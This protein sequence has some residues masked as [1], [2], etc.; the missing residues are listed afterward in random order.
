MNKEILLAA[1]SQHY[2]FA[3]L[4]TQQKQDLLAHSRVQSFAQGAIVFQKNSPAKAFYFVL[5]GGVRLYFSAPDG[6]EKTVRIFEAGDS[7]AEALMFMQR[8]SYPANAM[9]IA[10]S[11]LL[12]VDSAYY[13]EMIVNNSALATALLGHCCEHIHQLSRQIEM[14]SVLDARSRFIEY[15]VKSAKKQNVIYRQNG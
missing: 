4:N 6:K 13:R 11:Q 3:P 14:L 8:T 15:I 7:F 10:P 1:V 9:T 5:E 2:L 12:A